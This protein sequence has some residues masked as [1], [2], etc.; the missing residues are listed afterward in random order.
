MTELYS[1]GELFD[2]IVAVKHFSERQAADIIRQILSAIY[3]CHRNNIVHRDLKPENILY[4]SEKPDSLLKIIDFG[5][6][7]S[8][9]TNQKMTQKFG[10]VFKIIFYF[11]FLIYFLSSNNLF[12]LN[13][14][15]KSLY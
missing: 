5:T 11:N 7:K 14:L 15:K 2:K 6:S 12:N 4:E 1:G 9:N 10:T 3:Y 8:F 13:N